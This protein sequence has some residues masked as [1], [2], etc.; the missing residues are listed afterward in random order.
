MELQDQR[1]LRADQALQVDQDQLDLRALQEAQDQAGLLVLQVDL[2]AQ[3][4]LVR[5]DRQGPLEQLDIQARVA[6]LE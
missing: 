5:R 3:V 2:E 4:H 1:V 6:A